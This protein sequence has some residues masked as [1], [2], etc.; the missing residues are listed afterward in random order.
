M[1]PLERQVL[2]AIHEGFFKSNP[3]EAEE[4]I[5]KFLGSHSTKCLEFYRANFKSYFK[6]MQKFFPEL[7][8]D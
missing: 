5:Q 4:I 1:S 7:A 2:S 6:S 8:T 3:E